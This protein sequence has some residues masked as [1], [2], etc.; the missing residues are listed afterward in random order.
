V[1][2]GGVA[3]DTVKNIENVSGG[4]GNDTLKGDSAANRLDGNGGN[5]TLYGAGGIDTLRGGTGD[6]T[7]VMSSTGD[8][9]SE[10]AGQGVDT[11][12]SS[13]S[14]VLSASQEIENLTLTGSANI[15]A[16]GN[17]LANVLTGNSG[18]NNLNGA[19][20]ADTMQGGGGNDTY[21]VDD[22]D[23][24]TIE[25]DGNGT[26]LVQSSVT[27]SIA[28]QFVENLTLTGSGSIDATGNS[29][30]NTIIGNSGINTLQG[31][32]GNDTLDGGGGV[33]AADYRDKTAA[34]SVTLNGASNAVVGVGG[35]AEDVI[36]NIENVYGGSG[37]DTLTGDGLANTLVGNAG[38][39][40]LNGGG[41]ADTLQGSSG[42]DTLFGD[43]DD[44]L[45]GGSGNDTLYGTGADALLGG[46]GNDTYVVSG[47]SGTI[48]EFAGLGTDSVESSASFVLSAGQEIENLTLTGSDNIDGTGN[49]LDNALTGNSGANTLNGGGGNDILEGGNG[50]DTLDG[51]TGADTMEG[52]NHN[53]TYVVDNAGDT[54]VEAENGATDL[55]QS[56]VTLSL[57]QFVENLTLT[58][59]GNINGTGNS[60]SNVLAG[61]S[62]NNTLDGGDGYDVLDGGAGADTLDG[63]SGNDSYVIDD[64]GDRLIETDGNGT[65]LVQNSVSFS[66]AGQYVENMTLTGS[67]DIDGTGNGVDNVLT[68]NSGNNRLG[69]G[70]GADTLRGGGGL[71]TLDGGAGA[72]DIADYRDKSASVVVTLNGASSAT[73]NVGG[74]AEDTVKNIE[75][76]YGGSGDDTLI[77]DNLNNTFRAGGGDNTLDGG[78]GIDTADYSYVGHQDIRVTLNGSGDGTV[79]IDIL[80]EDDTLRN[81]ENVRTG[82][83]FDTLTGDALDNLLDGGGNADTMQ[84]GAG[85][86]TYVVDGGDTIVEAA[87]EGTDTVQSST[88]SIALAEELENVTLTGSANIS[89]SGNGGDNLLIGSSGNNNLNGGSG[90]DTMQGGAGNDTYVVDDAGDLVIET[91]ATAP[92]RW[93]A[94]SAIRL[95]PWPSSRT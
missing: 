68:G 14:F 80:S 87:G 79:T 16:T 58:G 49:S 33:D 34:V 30:A 73:V 62:G 65:D 26:D 51:G 37:G 19:A 9:I 45:Q 83:G 63:G 76:V 32:K 3:E 40:T 6:D 82:L 56:S 88:Q 94:P 12:N 52:G 60:L 93:K 71:D 28:G 89:G 48:T 24:Q 22:I 75:N 1:T 50:T 67:A 17:G 69:G 42:N 61:N 21:V 86:D 54:I 85:N 8:I 7:Y 74:I 72:A 92:T 18:D 91:A 59:T 77:G 44:T 4:S 66:I 84:G 55:V 46:A 23:D 57:V 5:D 36:R 90:A 43:G 70:G 38:D 39:D 81:I 64:A 2:V 35:V 95:P 10:F 15:D 53:D 41:G 78:D 20:G 31:G 47:F 27:F 25:T 29:L 13:A 11:V